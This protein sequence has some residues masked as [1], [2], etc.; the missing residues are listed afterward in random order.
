MKYSQMPA[1]YR[2][3]MLYPILVALSHEYNLVM[4]INNEQALQSR[5]LLP[6]N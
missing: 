5:H 3:S 1:A 6:K 2:S 4:W